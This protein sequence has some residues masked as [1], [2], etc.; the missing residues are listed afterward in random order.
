MPIT[1]REPARRRTWQR[2]SSVA[3]V[4]LLAF[5]WWAFLRP[6]TLGGPLTLVTVTGVSMEPGFQTGDLAVMRAADRYDQG[7]VVAF[8]SE[9]VPGTTGA[10]VIHRIVGGNGRTGYVT[11]GDNN[12][13]DDPWRPTA[14]EVTGR[15]WFAV[16]GAGTALRWLTHPVHLGALLAALAAAMTMLGR[17]DEERRRKAARSAG[18]TP[19]SERP[20]V[21][22]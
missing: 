2:V 12:D 17:P 7:D 16:P 3:L 11:R 1:V 10:Y 8:R 22:A 9:P 5:G 19:A 4:G 21:A 20:A 13:W 15:L 14:A 6:S 18:R